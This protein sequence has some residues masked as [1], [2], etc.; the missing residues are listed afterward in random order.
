MKEYLRKR[1]AVGRSV[2][3]RG[4]VAERIS[5]TTAARRRIVAGRITDLIAAAA[6]ILES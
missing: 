5:A 3:T 6:A 2:E 1:R 4:E